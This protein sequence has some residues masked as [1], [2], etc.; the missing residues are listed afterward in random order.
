MECLLSFF[1]GINVLFCTVKISD[2]AGT[3]LQVN[4]QHK[5]NE[6]MKKSL[7]ILWMALLLGSTLWAQTK[8]GMNY[9][10]NI[11]AGKS[12]MLFIE[13]QGQITDQ[14]GQVR[15]DIDFKLSTPAMTLF[16]GAGKIEY[17][18][19]TKVDTA[20][21]NTYRL[22]VQLENYNTQT[23]LE[24][25][26][27][28][29][30]KEHYYVNKVVAT[31][32][33][34]TTIVY[35]DI[36]PN[37]DW[38]IYVAQD[39]RLKYDFVVRAGGNPDKIK[40]NYAGATDLQLDATGNLMITT[41][42]GKI[43]EKAP[44]SYVGNG[45]EQQL[46]PSSYVL[47]GNELSFQVAPYQGT[48]TIDPEIDWATFYG[49]TDFD[50]ENENYYGNLANSLHKSAAD[51]LGNVFIG[52]YTNA[53]NNIA[54]TGS[55]LQELAT[56]QD[57]F[58]VKFDNAGNRLWGT[59]YY[60]GSAY[61]ANMGA[62]ATDHHG[63]LYFIGNGIAYNEN[64]CTE[65]AHQD[66]FRSSHTSL[67]KLSG[68]GERIWSSYYGGLQPSDASNGA[69]LG[70]YAIAVDMDNN[71][72]LIGETTE[73]NNFEFFDINNIIATNGAHKE[74]HSY[75]PYNTRDIFIAK[76][77]SLGVRQWGTY[78][79][80][81]DEDIAGGVWGE[82]T[83]NCA[84]TDLEGNLYLVGYTRSSDGISTPGSY[85]ETLALDNQFNNDEDA[86]IAK[87]STSGEL[88]W[89]TYYG[90]AGYDY[91]YSVDLD[92]EGNLVLLGVTQSKTNITTPDA[93]QDTLAFDFGYSGFPFLAKF[94][95]DGDRLWGSYFNDPT[96]QVGN[97]GLEL[98]NLVVDNND[99]YW[100]L[101]NVYGSNSDFFQVGD[102]WNPANENSYNSILVQFKDNEILWSTYIDAQFKSISID[103]LSNLYLA[104]DANETSYTSPGAF[105]E[106]YIAQYAT[107]YLLKS[108]I[109]DEHT[110]TV[111]PS[112]FQPN[113]AI[114]PHATITFSVN[115]GFDTYTWTLPSGWTGTSD[116]NSIEVQVNDQSGMITVSG[117]Y[118]CGTSADLSVS[119]DI[120]DAAAID[121]TVSNDTLYAT[122]YDAYTWYFND[123][124]IAGAS[125]AYIILDVAGIYK[126]VVT[127]EEGCMV[128]ASYEYGGT[129]IEELAADAI[130]IYP[131][132]ATKQL[133]IDLQAKAQYAVY[134]VQGRLVLTS[135]NN[136]IDISK[137]SN[138][139]Y[140]LKITD[141]EGRIIKTYPFVK[142]SH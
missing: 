89:G 104:G 43:T 116:S 6:I 135:N 73:M 54:T 35:K 128:S 82:K 134:D 40:I 125:E 103:Q 49:G 80:G 142:N 133:T 30:F 107:S 114:C 74:D 98:K 41:P 47:Q 18:W 44:Y 112:N 17:Q 132:P 99:N 92:S 63:N 58:V 70:G 56:E 68:D 52:G 77:D 8:A 69:T 14:Q 20:V 101:F 126:A 124:L 110:N 12:P 90:G 130:K 16:I 100:I 121:F 139:H 26:V 120:I 118:Q 33:A 84:V 22:D 123:E 95:A 76:F 32:A 1:Y 25:G 10:H 86:F 93:F 67:V 136:S 3:N 27:A 51:G 64:F 96:G 127:T 109:C 7:S 37:I 39:N 28:A 59:Y 53:I 34:Y 15:N 62:M 2:E 97:W 81:L 105:E 87:F 4:V 94:S 122:G 60:G 65:N 72:F 19:V 45:K 31:A 9:S 115:P 29:G 36:Y 66:T 88:L 24:P 55:F 5:L 83:G 23:K 102:Q 57:L 113:Q 42:A 106:D 129:G 71:V 141:K 131:N 108:T 38:V 78:Y 21:T 119:L 140:L 61:G 117:D 75:G 50:E 11:Q 137:M 79:G 46:I 138:G 85:Q 111:T 48:L 13:Q 91:L